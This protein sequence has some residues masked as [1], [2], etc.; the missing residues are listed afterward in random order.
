MSTR[1]QAFFPASGVYLYTHQQGGDLLKVV[2][3]ALSHGVRHRDEE[4]LA[5]ILLVGMRNHLNSL[6]IDQF[7]SLG[8][9]TAEHPDIDFLLT[10]D[11]DRREITVE[12]RGCDGRES[13]T[14]TFEEIVQGE[15]LVLNQFLEGKR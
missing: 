12:H 8:I 5:A 6:G 3:K 14:R 11:T 7:A 15:V 1:A 9:S 10:L 2:Q 4:Y 13:Y